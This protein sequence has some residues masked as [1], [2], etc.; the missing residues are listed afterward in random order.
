MYT[1]SAFGPD[2]KAAVEL[3]EKLEALMN[4]YGLTGITQGK[5]YEGF[6]SF[7]GNYKK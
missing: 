3:K 6:A 5:G 4:E 1:V 7:S 2:S